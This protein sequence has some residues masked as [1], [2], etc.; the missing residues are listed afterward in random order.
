MLSIPSHSHL[1]HSCIATNALC[2]GNRDLY[3]LDT[4]CFYEFRQWRRG[5]AAESDGQV[6]LNLSKF[7]SSPLTSPK[8][9]TGDLSF[10]FFFVN[11]LCTEPM[12]VFIF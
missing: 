10:I 1:T 2:T 12:E 8:K 6:L 4:I 11:Q 7:F 5:S 3:A 9:F